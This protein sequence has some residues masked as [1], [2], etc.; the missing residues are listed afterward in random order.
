MNVSK[1][2]REKGYTQESFSEKS[3]ISLGTIKNLGSGKASPTL[4]T[5]DLVAKELGCVFIDLFDLDEI[6]GSTRYEIFPKGEFSEHVDKELYQRIEQLKR[7]KQGSEAEQLQLLK[8]Y[9]KL[10]ES[11]RSMEKSVITFVDAMKILNE[12][13]D[14][15]TTTELKTAIKGMISD[16]VKT[17]NMEI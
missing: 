8:K 5:L 13:I 10:Y 7:E 15:M 17:P 12:N 6:K 2:I 14:S 1:M 16:L 3:K 9:M 4:K 11:L